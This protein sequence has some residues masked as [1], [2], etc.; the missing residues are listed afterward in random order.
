MNTTI[1]SR[2]PFLHVVSQNPKVLML[3]VLLNDQNI[4][5]LLISEDIHENVHEKITCYSGKYTENHWY[6]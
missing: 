4:L 1:S 2:H 5:V 3:F 6:F